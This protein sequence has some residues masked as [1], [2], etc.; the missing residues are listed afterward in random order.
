MAV[1]S[2]SFDQPKLVLKT[3]FSGPKKLVDHTEYK[4]D[5]YQRGTLTPSASKRDCGTRSEQPCASVYGGSPGPEEIHS[6][7]LFGNF[8]KAAITAKGKNDSQAS[9][10]TF[11]IKSRYSSDRTLFNTQDIRQGEI[12]SSIPISRSKTIGYKGGTADETLLISSSINPLTTQPRTKNLDLDFGPGNNHLK[13]DA[14]QGPNKSLGKITAK[15]G[16]GDDLID[17]NSGAHDPLFAQKLTI[18]TGDGDDKINRYN[19][20]GLIAAKKMYFNLG[21]GA[22][23]MSIGIGEKVASEVKSIVIDLGKDRDDDHVDIYVPK[24]FDE[25]LISFKNFRDEDFYQ[26]WNW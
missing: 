6:F 13:L 22:D 5:G 2:F 7:E 8:K 9:K 12:N 11:H 24:D 16:D 19:R 14:F 15:F 21:S 3:E 10:F 20:G 4:E 1:S 18:K 26:I 25:S 23:G 17:L